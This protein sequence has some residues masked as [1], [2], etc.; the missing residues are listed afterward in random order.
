MEMGIGDGKSTS[1]E[2]RGPAPNPRNTDN[3]NSKNNDFNNF[4]NVNRSPVPLTAG[5]AVDLAMLV[6]TRPL[7]ASDLA[8]IRPP[9]RSEIEKDRQLA[10]PL[11]DAIKHGDLPSTKLLY[12]WYCRGSGNEELIHDSGGDDATIHRHLFWLPLACNPENARQKLSSDEWYKL[13]ESVKD[14]TG[15]QWTDEIMVGGKLK[16]AREFIDEVAMGEVNRQ[17]AAADS[18]NLPPRVVYRMVSH[19]KKLERTLSLVSNQIG[20][21]SGSW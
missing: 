18:K 7:V 14:M 2:K 8:S 17:I 21:R 15:N 10:L 20:T 4:A 9:N 13:A 16:N 5:L 19:R 6:G 1:E 3:N 12:D 11:Q